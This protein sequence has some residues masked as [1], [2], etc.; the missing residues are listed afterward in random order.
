GIQTP[1]DKTIVFKLKAPASDFLNV[2]GMSFTTPVPEEVVSPY[3]TDSPEFRQHF[4]STGPYTLT[5]YVPDKS[6]TLKR[7]PDYDK[8]KDP[9]REAYVDQI[10]VDLTVGSDDAEMQQIQ[11]GS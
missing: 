6:Y 10:D 7:I 2:M 1:N 4:V 9:L 5:S 3:L 11:A 8:A